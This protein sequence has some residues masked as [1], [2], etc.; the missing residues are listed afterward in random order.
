MPRQPWP[1]DQNGVSTFL[2]EFHR[3]QLFRF[4]IFFAKWM[5]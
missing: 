4:Q 1:K 5:W 3:G 2:T